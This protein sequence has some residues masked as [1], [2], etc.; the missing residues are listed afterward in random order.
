MEDQMTGQ[1][2]LL[3]KQEQGLLSIK[4]C[5]KRRWTGKFGLKTG[6]IKASGDAVAIL[7]A[8]SV[9]ISPV[10]TRIKEVL[11]MNRMTHWRVCRMQIYV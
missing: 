1:L 9:I 5:H 4:T 3:K 7:H 8:D 10:F 6:L 11:N 2:K